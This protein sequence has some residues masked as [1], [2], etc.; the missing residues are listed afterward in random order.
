M[1]VR[2]N[3]TLRHAVPTRIKLMPLSEDNCWNMFQFRHSGRMTYYVNCVIQ[4]DEGYDIGYFEKSHLDR[5]IIKV[6]TK[7]DLLEKGR[8][9]SFFD[10]EISSFS[11]LICST[12]IL[13]SRFLASLI[14][15]MYAFK[16]FNL[17]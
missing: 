8:D 11:L 4:T 2:K 13:F 3:E 14:F 6:L 15:S 12:G 5:P 1:R 9:T 17:L 16:R 10:I 7:S